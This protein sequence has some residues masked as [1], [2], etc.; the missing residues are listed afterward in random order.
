MALALRNPNTIMQS[1]PDTY[2]VWGW[3][4]G[5]TTNGYTAGSAA[6]P[7]MQVELVDSSGKNVWQPNSNATEYGDVAILMDKPAEVGNTGIDDAVAAG[8]NCEV[9]WLR[10]GAIF[11]GKVVSG[12]TA[13]NGAI[14]QP[15]GN[16]WHKAATATTADANLGRFKCL[17]NLGTVSSDTRAR[18]MF[19]G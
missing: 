19:R 18:I 7:G 15:N 9:A 13:A 12:Q 14:L 6:T 4:D 2:T 10:A 17:D 16:G 1:G 3:S 8:E 11:Y 5:A